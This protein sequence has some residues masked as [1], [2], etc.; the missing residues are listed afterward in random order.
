MLLED[1]KAHGI[2]PSRTTETDLMNFN[3]NYALV[4]FGLLEHIST[5]N[6]GSVEYGYQF[7]VE[8]GTLILKPLFRDNK[9]QRM[10]FKTLVR[11]YCENPVL[12]HRDKIME[13]TA[14]GVC[15][16]LSREAVRRNLG[17]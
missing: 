8:N 16:I 12:R 9:K 17:M 13:K 7:L 11:F 14:T 10:T 1:L 15:K 3:N 2:L 6:A 4:G 5:S